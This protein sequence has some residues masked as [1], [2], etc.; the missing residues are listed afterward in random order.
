MGNSALLRLVQ[1]GNRAEK[2]PFIVANGWI[3]LPLWWSVNYF[4]CSKFLDIPETSWRRKRWRKPA[5]A[6]RFAFQANSNILTVFT[7]DRSP[8]IFTLSTNQDEGRGKGL[9]KFNNSLALNSDFVDKMKSHTANTQKI[10]D[11]GN[12]REDQA[13]WE[14]LKYE[15]RKFSIK[16][17]KLLSENTKTRITL[18]VFTAWKKTKIIK[19]YFKLFE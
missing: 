4:F 18:L 10:L 17:S 12:I 13:R 5:S 11:K 2:F 8:L 1:K 16:F 14:Y 15:I 6:N 9:W 7:S 3:V 19:M